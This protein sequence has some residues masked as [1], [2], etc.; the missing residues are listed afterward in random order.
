MSSD[1]N[2]FQSAYLNFSE[3]TGEFDQKFLLC[4]QQRKI[5]AE[6]SFWG[7]NASQAW[8]DMLD[9]KE[10]EL[11]DSE[12]RI[13][14]KN[15]LKIQKK[16]P[17]EAINCIS[18]CCGILDREKFLLSE[19]SKIQNITYVPIDSSID[20]INASLRT[21]SPVKNIK[22]LPFV[23]T[24]ASLPKIST[25]MRKKHSHTSLFTLFCNVLGNYPQTAF[26]HNIHESMGNDDFFLVGVQTISEDTLSTKRN[27][28]IQNVLSTY[29]NSPYS[30][31][32]FQFIARAG[33]KKEDGEFEIEFGPDKLYPSLSVVECYFRFRTEKKI[34]Y[35]GEEIVYR[36]G[37]RI[38]IRQSY[39][40]T[41]TEIKRL[42]QENGFSINEIFSEKEKD[43]AIILCQ[44]SS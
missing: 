36:K 35:L 7:R 6:F 21:M 34:Q 1:G 8:V 44:K 31:F 24:L 29:D 25:L 39:I 28:E 3:S 41:M 15:I 18:L 26:L 17:K 2:I 16:L 20:I 9:V 11:N 37:E 10:Y 14:E 13:L 38:Q 42:L 40:Y 23:S 22:I 5:G 43:Y 12:K 19:L 27:K 33:F 30:E 4:L 32:L